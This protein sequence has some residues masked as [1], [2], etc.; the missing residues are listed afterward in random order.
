[1]LEQ[2]I[3]KSC[4]IY[5]KWFAVKNLSWLIL[6]KE[7]V[8]T[9]LFSHLKFHFEPTY[10]IK[11][12]LEASHS[13]HDWQQFKKKRRGLKKEQAIMQKFCMC[14]L[15]VPKLI[16][17]LIHTWQLLLSL[18]SCFSGESLWIHYFQ[19]NLLLIWIIFSFL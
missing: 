16:P 2:N 17:W 18:V 14:S 8:K 3:A 1:M 11:P 15:L 4:R 10:Y 7:P 19:C 6:W 5:I 12:W 13:F 9:W